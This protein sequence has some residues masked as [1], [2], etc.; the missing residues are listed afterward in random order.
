MLFH[1]FKYA[2]SYKIPY[3]GCHFDSLLELKYALSIEGTHRYLREPFIIGYDP[4]TLRTTNYFRETTKLYTPDFLIRSKTTKASVLIEVKP[5]RLKNSR[6]I[7]IYQKICEDYIRSN[8]LDCSFRIVSEDDMHLN[9]DQLARYDLFV[10]KKHSFE[11]VF[12]FKSLDRRYNSA[13]IKYFHNVPRF[14]DDELSH[15][16][17]AKFVRYGPVKQAV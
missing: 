16:E 12:A 5:S 9:D 14:P 13:H 17:Y 2:K 6:A 11:S 3:R 1:K 4:N 7:S 10:R 8:H 15:S